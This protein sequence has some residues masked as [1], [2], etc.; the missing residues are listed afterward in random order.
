MGMT[1][2]Q[3]MQVIAA[4]LLGLFAVTIGLAGSLAGEIWLLGGAIVLGAV[5][6]RL[7]ELAPRDAQ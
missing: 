2:K 4:S 5:S 1:K 6:W 3:R 7:I